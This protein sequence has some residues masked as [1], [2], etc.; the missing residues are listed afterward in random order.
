LQ[1]NCLRK[2]VPNGAGGQVF[3]SIL[4]LIGLAG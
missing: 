4:I 2:V 3:Y 1:L